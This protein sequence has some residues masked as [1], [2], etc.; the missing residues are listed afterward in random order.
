MYGNNIPPTYK[1]ESM[2]KLMSMYALLL[3]TYV[4]ALGTY[5]WLEHEPWMIA[6]GTLPVLLFMVVQLVDQWFEKRDSFWTTTA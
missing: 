6:L 2:M 3:G 4:L 1:R 5:S